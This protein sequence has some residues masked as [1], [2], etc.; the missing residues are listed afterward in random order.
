MIKEH[1]PTKWH[2]CVSSLINACVDE[3][4]SS[5][6]DV[7]DAA[8]SMPY[9]IDVRGSLEEVTNDDTCGQAIISDGN[10]VFIDAF[11]K[12]NEMENCFTHGI[13]TNIG[14]W[15]DCA[16]NNTTTNEQF[17]VV[18]NQP[19]MADIHARNVHQTYANHKYLQIY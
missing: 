7:L 13:E 6:Q 17:S 9:L 18:L 4:N 3:T 14:N 16:P 8:A 11:I 19:N 1:G 2:D 10:D 15:D 5:K 12:R